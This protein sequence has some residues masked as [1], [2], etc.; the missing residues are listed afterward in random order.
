VPPIWQD[1][2]AFIAFRWH[3]TWR[4]LSRADFPLQSRFANLQ[5]SSHH[6]EETDVGHL[7]GLILI[8]FYF[9]ASLAALP[10]LMVVCRLLRLKVSINALV[11]SAIGLSLLL[12]VVPLACHWL[13]LAAFTGRRML[14][15]GLLSFLFAATDVALVKRLPLPLDDELQAL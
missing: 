9:F 11:G 8:P 13:D 6:A 15:L 7:H 4:E 10:F 14:V 1:G 5:S 3:D 2:D 12:I